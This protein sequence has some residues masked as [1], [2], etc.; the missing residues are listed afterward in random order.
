MS[1]AVGTSEGQD[2]PTLACT[3]ARCWRVTTQP[4]SASSAAT[5]SSTHKTKWRS[6]PPWL[7]VDGQCKALGNLQLWRNPGVVVVGHGWKRREQGGDGAGPD[8]FS[9]LR[10][11]VLC[12]K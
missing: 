3:S 2:K 4:R 9:L 5:L 8:L 10:S 11:E 7:L 12:A 6:L 1:I